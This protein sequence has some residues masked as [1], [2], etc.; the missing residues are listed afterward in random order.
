VI[1]EIL[2]RELGIPSPADTVVFCILALFVIYVPTKL[3]HSI[4]NIFYGASTD[5]EPNAGAAAVDP[6]VMNQLLS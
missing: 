5:S 4:L 3:I 2:N 1:S 6:N